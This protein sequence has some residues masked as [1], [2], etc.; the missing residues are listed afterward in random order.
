MFARRAALVAVSAWWGAA[1][2]PGTAAAQDAPG[3]P[4]LANPATAQ[5]LPQV[6]I[7]GTA[8]LRELGQPLSR[9]EER[10]VGKECA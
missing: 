8:P 6:L 5:E 1:S 4:P 10:R 3:N 9:S 7:I 2:L